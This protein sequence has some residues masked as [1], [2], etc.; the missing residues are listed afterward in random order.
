MAFELFNISVQH[1]RGSQVEDISLASLPGMRDHQLYSQREKIWVNIGQI[2]H[3]L[4]LTTHLQE[5][6]T[7]IGVTLYHYGFFGHLISSEK[8]QYFSC[9]LSFKQIRILYI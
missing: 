1:L 3:D 5:L 9:I 8:L 6:L 7:F 2:T 4:L